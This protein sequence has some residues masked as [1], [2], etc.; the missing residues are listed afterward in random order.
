MFARSHLLNV[1]R[2]AHAVHEIFEQMVGFVQIFPE[3]LPSLFGIFAEQRQRTFV[4]ARRMQFNVDL[5]VF[6]KR[7]KLGICA[8]TPI[9]PIME[10]GAATILSATHAII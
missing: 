2:W 8:T 6:R 1:Q 5:F 9:E 7:L 10:N 3:F 4:L